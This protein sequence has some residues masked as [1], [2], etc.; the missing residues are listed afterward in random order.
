MKTANAL[1]QVFQNFGNVEM[2]AILKENPDGSLILADLVKKEKAYD[3]ANSIEG[4]DT[5]GTFVRDHRVMILCN[6]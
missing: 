2:V 4:Y 3:L 6:D 5:M 1:M